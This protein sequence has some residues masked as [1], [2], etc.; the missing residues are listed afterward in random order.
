MRLF[1]GAKLLD[2]VAEI[3]VFVRLMDGLGV[4]P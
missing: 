3:T 4:I 2:A 1:L